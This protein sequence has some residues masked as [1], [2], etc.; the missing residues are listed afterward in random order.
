M[1]EERPHYGSPELE[2]K[3]VAAT[4]KIVDEKTNARACHLVANSVFRP[5][6]RNVF[7]RKA[8][9][10]TLIDLLQPPNKGLI[11]Y[12]NRNAMLIRKMK[13]ILQ[14]DLNKAACVALTC[15]SR[16]LDDKEQLLLITAELIQKTLILYAVTDDSRADVKHAALDLLKM[17]NVNV[18]HRDPTYP[19]EELVKK[20]SY[21][22]KFKTNKTPLSPHNL[23]TSRSR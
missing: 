2:V 3:L 15:L 17:Y 7:M 16:A 4:L 20:D 6:F 9:Y 22:K 5:M 1:E 10:L 18:G 13:P 12:L 14:A 11:P 23:N 8:H 19:K 21:Y